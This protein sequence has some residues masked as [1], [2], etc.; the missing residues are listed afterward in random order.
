MYIFK[1]TKYRFLGIFFVVAI[2][3]A[4]GWNIY[5][6]ENKV[7]LADLG[8]ANIEALAEGETL[9]FGECWYYGCTFA[10]FYDCRVY[11]TPLMEYV[12]LC[13]NHR[14]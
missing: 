6:S 8:L 9:S 1:Q 7:A 2:A 12:G 5:Q 14:G 3:L 4:A 11:R 13:E 10:F